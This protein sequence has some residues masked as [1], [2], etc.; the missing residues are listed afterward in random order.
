MWE[1]QE[2]EATLLPTPTVGDFQK[3]RLTTGNT[4]SQNGLTNL[5]RVQLAGEQ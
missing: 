1:A 2:A 4:Q 3:G 5:I